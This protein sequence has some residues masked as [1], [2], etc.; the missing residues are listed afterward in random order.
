MLTAIVLFL[1]LPVALYEWLV[2]LKHADKKV[3]IIH[4]SVMLVSFCVL[5]LYSLNVRVPSPTDMI[6]D[7]VESIFKLKG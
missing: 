1:F 5:M 2:T 7:V 6:M 3:K 4:T